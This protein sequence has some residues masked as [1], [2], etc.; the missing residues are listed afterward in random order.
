M[1]ASFQMLAP[2]PEPLLVWQQTIANSTDE[3]RN[4]ISSH[5]EKILPS[6]NIALRDYPYLVKAAKSS[7]DLRR[8]I[9]FAFAVFDGQERENRPEAIIHHSLFV[10]NLFT[11]IFGTKA[12]TATIAALLHDVKEDTTFGHLIQ[13]FFGDDVDREVDSLSIFPKQPAGTQARI[14][15]KRQLKLKQSNNLSLIGLVIKAI[16]NYHEV[17]CNAQDLE[18]GLLQIQDLKVFRTKP[19]TYTTVDGFLSKLADRDGLNTNYTTRIRSFRTIHIF[20]RIFSG[21]RA[22]QFISKL[23]NDAYARQENILNLAIDNHRQ[24]KDTITMTPPSLWKVAGALTRRA[25]SGSADLTR[26]ASRAFTSLI[27]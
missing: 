3:F 22:S 12:D 26:R 23:F 15:E 9:L 4:C 25:V 20:D 1:K 6:L 16:D 8:A 10:A 27:L 11:Q 24:Q 17:L 19:K 5:V 7:Y 21:L 2:K 14:L 18:S 13:K